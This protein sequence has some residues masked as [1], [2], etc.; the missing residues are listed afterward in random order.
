MRQIGDKV[1]VADF[2]NHT[3]KNVTCPDCGGTGRLRVIFHDETQVSIDC[4][5]CA[6]GY[7]PPKGYV[8]IYTSEASAI[9][10]TI[11]EVRQTKDGCEYITTRRHVYTEK[12]VFDNEQDALNCALK[13]EAEY[14]KEQ[15]ERIFKKEKDTRSWAWNASYHRKQ[16]KKANESIAYHTKKLNAANLK[17]KAALEGR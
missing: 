16:I 6:S 15:E 14:I 11:E 9:I 3:I 7:E 17:G 10:D 8:G 2:K 4:Q 1:W 12:D 13:K 5:N